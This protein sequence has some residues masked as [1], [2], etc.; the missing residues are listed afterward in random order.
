MDNFTEEFGWL[1]PELVFKNHEF[2]RAYHDSHGS[3]WTFVKP[4]L[5][6][7]RNSSYLRAIERICLRQFWCFRIAIAIGVISVALAI[8]LNYWLLVITV[9]CAAIA[10][11]MARN[12]KF[13]LIQMRSLILSIEMLSLDF[14][15]WGHYF[16]S[17]KA[18]A[19][20]W[21]A[22]AEPGDET[23][24]DVYMPP[25]QREKFIDSFRPSERTIMRSMS[26]HL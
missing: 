21:L 19:I 11:L 23:L 15:G 20:E 24:I 14:A 26:Q 10:F 18:K 4:S 5:L 3:G 9:V 17:A 25:N 22:A 12:M 2:I 13:N 1:P 6:R 16:P 8:I 7:A